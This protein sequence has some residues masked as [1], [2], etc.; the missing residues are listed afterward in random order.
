MNPKLKQLHPYP[1]EKLK[2]LKH[3]IVPPTDKSAIALSIG[4]PKHPTPLFIQQALQQ[5]LP[6]LV[7]YP[8]TQG[9]D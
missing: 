4:E 7:N 2:Q 8:S 3:G 6:S 1:F 5:H 9:T